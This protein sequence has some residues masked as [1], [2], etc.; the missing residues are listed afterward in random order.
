MHP[1]GAR[2][3]MNYMNKN[4][5]FAASI[6]VV[7]GGAFWGGMSY[8]QGQ[9]PQRSGNAQFAGRPGGA[10]GFTRGG[11]GGGFTAGEIVSVA[12]GSITIQSPQSSSTEIVLTGPSTQIL[13]TVA[14]SQS[15]LTAGTN[16]VVTGSSNSDGSLTAQSIQIRPAGNN[17]PVTRGGSGTSSQ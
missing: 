11:A 12:G 8:A 6:V 3:R 7:A 9:A 4:L 15:D 16:V 17:T 2:I 1:R 10:G 13:K 14:G 5:I